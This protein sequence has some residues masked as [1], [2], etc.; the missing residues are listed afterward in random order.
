MAVITKPDNATYSTALNNAELLRE[1]GNDHHHI[2]H[3]VLFLEERNRMLQAV[4][5]AAEEYV[6]FGED[7][8]LHSKLLKA[9]EALDKYELET[10][11]DEPPGFGLDQG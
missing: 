3:A 11:T 7:S 8:Q 4:V 2:A 10:E 6:R 9:L 5:D 1:T